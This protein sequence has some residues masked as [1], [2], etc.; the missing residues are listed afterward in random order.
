MRLIITFFLCLYSFISTFGQDYIFFLHN[1]FLEDHE[2][3][4]KH[5]QYGKAAYQEILLE[6]EEAGFTVISEKR[7]TNT[8]VKKYAKKVVQ[9]IDSLLE[10][11][12]LPN[13]ITIIG[14]S[15]GGFIA[16]YVSTFLAQPSVNF[17][18]IGCF[19]EQHIEE[20]PDIQFCGNILTIY[21]ASDAYGVSAIQR[22]HTSRLQINEFKEIELHTNLGHSFL[23]QP[24]KEWI[25][26]CVKWAKG[27]Y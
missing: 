15:K 14:T 17:I 5:P 7:P 24:L 22:K 2:L 19:Q 26:P 12:V 20:Y 13:H 11:G 18:F 23:F 25:E 10:K 4:A 6:F 8:D 1:R 3:S 9:A 21:E 27:E 16:Q